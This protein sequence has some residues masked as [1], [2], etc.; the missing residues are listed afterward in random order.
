MGGDDLVEKRSLERGGGGRLC[1]LLGGFMKND[2]VLY[3]SILHVSLFFPPKVCIDGIC[4]FLII[5]RS[6]RALPSY[7]IYV[8]VVVVV[9]VVSSSSSLRISFSVCPFI[10]II[11]F[12]VN[13]HHHHHHHHPHTNFPSLQ[14]LA[15]SS[16][17]F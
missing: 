12:L 6:L 13:H 3:F 9:V 17:F 11:V 15:G 1:V 10:I 14:S 16:F 4:L 5:Y 7:V 8:V 2:L